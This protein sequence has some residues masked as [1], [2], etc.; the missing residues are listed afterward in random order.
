MPV[1]IREVLERL[2]ADG[3]VQVRQVGSH[4]QF[5]HPTKTG[6]V[7]IAGKLSLD[8]P[9]GTLSSIHKQAVLSKPRPRKR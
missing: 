3:W 9:P 8:V 6:T 7:T 2:R 5:H 4:R 1:T